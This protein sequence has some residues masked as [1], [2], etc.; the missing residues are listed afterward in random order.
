MANSLDEDVPASVLAD[1]CRRHVI[2]CLE[3]GTTPVALADLSR[4]VAVR[5]ENSTIT[6]VS[7]ERVQSIRTALYHTHLPQ[8]DDAGV[9]EFDPSTQWLWTD[10]FV[11][12]RTARLIF[13]V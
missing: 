7:D 4:D 10:G 5:E 11:Q 8:L 1:A 2:A 6:D 13:G 3:A 12:S 9:V